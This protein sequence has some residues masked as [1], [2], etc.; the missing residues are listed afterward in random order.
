MAG[1][2]MS[3]MKKITAWMLNEKMACE[4]ADKIQTR[5]L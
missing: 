2:A 4:L 3:T 1:E 5:R